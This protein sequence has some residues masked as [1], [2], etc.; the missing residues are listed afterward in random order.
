MY[1][2]VGNYPFDF[3][4]KINDFKHWREHKIDTYQSDDYW[5]LKGIE[6]GYGDNTLI[7]KSYGE[8]FPSYLKDYT[9][10]FDF[11][12]S[13]Q[14]NFHVQKPG[15]ILQ[16][17]Y[18]TYD[19]VENSSR[20]VVFMSEWEFGQVFMIEDLVVTNW[21]KGDTYHFDKKALHMSSNGSMKDK[22]T[23]S[24]TGVSNEYT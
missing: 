12:D 1:R 4:I 11:I 18:D 5:S 19:N 17:H 23:L 13:Y 15:M 22:L 6:V 9:E 10:Q 24:M 2:F 8:D 3:K 7:L 21:K 14:N 20:V 16:P